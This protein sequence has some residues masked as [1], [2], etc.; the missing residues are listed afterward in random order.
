MYI[1]A[2]TQVK[3]KRAQ[4]G[5]GTCATPHSSHAQQ[6]AAAAAAILSHCIVSH[7]YFVTER[8]IVVFVAV[9]LTIVLVLVDGICIGGRRPN[10]SGRGA[11]A[12]GRQPQVVRCAHRLPDMRALIV[13]VNISRACFLSL[14]EL[15][16]RGRRRKERRR[17]YDQSAVQ[18]SSDSDSD[19]ESSDSTPLCPHATLRSPPSVAIVVS[20]S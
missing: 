6:A 3:L 12:G 4:S 15:G 19:S 5:R 11:A 13:Y 9:V 8:R 16:A 20:V 10:G 18:G 2:Y 14:A 7:V 1:Y 17:D